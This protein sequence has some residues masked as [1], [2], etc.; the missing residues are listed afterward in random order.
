MTS[1]PEC[2]SRRRENQTVRRHTITVRYWWDEMWLWWAPDDN[3]WWMRMMVTT[4]APVIS[5]PLTG[6][7]P[8]LRGSTGEQTGGGAPGSRGHLS[9]LASMSTRASGQWS[10]AG[11]K[12]VVIINVWLCDIFPFRSCC[13]YDCLSLSNIENESF[14]IYTSGCGKITT[15]IL[16]MIG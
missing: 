10:G 13:L 6:D 14:L 9:Q 3:W 8:R 16:R 4:S 7:D 5:W 11:N 15:P 1:A 2:E 12:T